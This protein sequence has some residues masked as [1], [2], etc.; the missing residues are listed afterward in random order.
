V[1]LS[2]EEALAL[3]SKLDGVNQMVARLMICRCRV[4]HQRSIAVAS[5]VCGF[6][7]EADL[8]SVAFVAAIITAIDSVPWPS[9]FRVCNSTATSRM[10]PK[11]DTV[12]RVWHMTT[13]CAAIVHLM[14]TVALRVLV[15]NETWHIPSNYYFPTFHFY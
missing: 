6:R 10:L 14:V 8:G 9:T 4:A 15:K 1:V 5:K 13:S 7:H 3:I 2:H 12:F 11:T